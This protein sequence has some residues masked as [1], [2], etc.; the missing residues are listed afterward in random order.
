MQLPINNEYRL[1]SDTDNIILQHKAIVKEGPKKGQ[2]RWDNVGYFTTIGQA[3]TS[4]VALCQRH[5][6]VNSWSGMEKLTKRL[7]QEI[8]AISRAL[9]IRLD[10]SKQEK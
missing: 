8:S 1:T 3:L 4:F 2:I 6:S 9:D 10:P 5:S 7:Y